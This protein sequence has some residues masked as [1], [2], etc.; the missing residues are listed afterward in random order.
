MEVGWGGILI[1]LAQAQ[2]YAA[3]LTDLVCPLNSFAADLKAQKRGSHPQPQSVRKPAAGYTWDR[4][5]EP[6]LPLFTDEDLEWPAN[7]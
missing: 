2:E 7:I 4:P 3:Q 6:P 1:P 5:A